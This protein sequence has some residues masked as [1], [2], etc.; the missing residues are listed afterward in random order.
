VKRVR[1]VMIRTVLLAGAAAG[2][3]LATRDLQVRA[4][5]S[6]LEGT[7]G[8]IA[9]VAQRLPEPP[10]TDVVVRAEPIETVTVP[11]FAKPAPSIDA[12]VAPKRLLVKAA[13]KTLPPRLGTTTLPFRI[14]RAEL[15]A[16]LA[17]KCS[18]AR[19]KLARDESGKPVGLALYATGALA[20][21]GV[22]DGDVLVSANGY[23]LRTPE[24]AFTA[25]AELK[26]ATRVTVV[27][28]R[29]SAS[30]ALTAEL[31]SEP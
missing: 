14:T 13:P 19:T 6:S 8:A 10:S 20:R 25:V 24:D 31:A 9:D 28:R 7:G 21:F 30:Y 1:A 22:Q 5:A 2:L 18:G 12:A 23:P 27:L 15:D 26:D 16:A 29:G 3:A 4:I 17:S 11:P